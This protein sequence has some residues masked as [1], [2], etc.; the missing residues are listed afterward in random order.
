MIPLERRNITI[1]GDR[2]LVFD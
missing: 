2:F 1:F